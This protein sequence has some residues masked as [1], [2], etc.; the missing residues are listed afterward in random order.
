MKR[1]S[2]VVTHHGEREFQ[3]H[4]LRRGAAFDQDDMAGV[5]TATGVVIRASGWHRGGPMLLA[6]LLNYPCR[7]NLI[8]D[9]L[10]TQVVFS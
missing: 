8:I 10:Y 3:V 1:E 2:F 7:L 5:M 4:G 9:G 6:P